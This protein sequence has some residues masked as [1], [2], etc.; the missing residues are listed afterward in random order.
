MGTPP[1]GWLTTTPTGSGTVDVVGASTSRGASRET[2]KVSCNWASAKP[3][4]LRTPC[5]KG[6]YAARIAAC[7]SSVGSRNRSGSKRSGSAQVFGSR[8]ARWA[9]QTTVVVAGTR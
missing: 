1:A 4:Q 3:M 8:P 6:T 7:C 5:P 2:I 9:D